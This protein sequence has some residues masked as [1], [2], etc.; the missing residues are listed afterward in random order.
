MQTLLVR[1]IYDSG[2]VTGFAETADGFWHAFL[3]KNNASPM[4]DLGRSRSGP[5]CVHERLWKIP[6]R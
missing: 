4:L 6:G 3:W 2:Q 1:R 5:V